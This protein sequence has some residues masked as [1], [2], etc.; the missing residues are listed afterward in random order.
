MYKLNPGEENNTQSIPEAR[1]IDASCVDRL[2]QSG[3]AEECR[4]VLRAFFDE[5]G[6]EGLSSLIFR[7]YIV[8]DAY[9]R[10]CAFANRLGVSDAEFAAAFGGADGIPARSNSRESAL[11][12][13]A[14]MIEDCI[15]WRARLFR[16]GKEAAVEKAKQYINENYN[17]EDISL[18]EAAAAVNLSPTYFSALFRKNT[19]TNFVDYLSLIRVNRAKELLCCTLMQVSEIAYEVGYKDYRYFGKVFKKYTGQT[20]REYQKKNNK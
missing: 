8:T 12:Y 18:N 11:S 19:G 3:N 16:G 10:A 2:L 4:P 6:G 7:Q 14:D 9:L 1:R 5:A 15:A 13:L 20:P 17:S